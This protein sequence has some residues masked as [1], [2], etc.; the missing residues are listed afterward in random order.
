[1]NA[2]CRWLHHE[3]REL[4]EE[5]YVLRHKA[6]CSWAIEWEIQLLPSIP[7]RHRLSSS[8]WRV[9][10]PLATPEAI[11]IIGDFEIT[12]QSLAFDILA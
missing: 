4:H 7:V 9:A 1:M 8:R 6:D 12:L 3:L 11:V 10:M 2:L 5:M